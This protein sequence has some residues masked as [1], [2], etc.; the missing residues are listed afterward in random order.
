MDKDT[1]PA[2]GLA[3]AVA[4]SGPEQQARATLGHGQYPPVGPAPS[5]YVY[6]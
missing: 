1:A 3:I 4:R 5:T 6:L 2:G